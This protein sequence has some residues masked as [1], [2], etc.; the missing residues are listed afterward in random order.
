MTLETALSE[1]AVSGK[2]FHVRG[3]VT[4]IAICY[5]SELAGFM[6]QLM[7]YR[8]TYEFHVRHAM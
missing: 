8:P 4:T 5:Q 1:R 6:C 7:A 2:L 3:P